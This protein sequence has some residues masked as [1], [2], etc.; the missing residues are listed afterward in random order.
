MK[1]KITSDN[2]FLRVFKL[3]TKFS[4]E[5]CFGGG[6]PHEFVMVNWLNV[7][8]PFEIS[9]GKEFTL[10]E[11]HDVCVPHMQKQEFLRKGKYLILF[12]CGAAIQF[13]KE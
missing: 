13:E 4:S 9:D 5:Y 10:Q 11:L 12:E 3:P 8:S 7:I 1:F 6:I 2:N